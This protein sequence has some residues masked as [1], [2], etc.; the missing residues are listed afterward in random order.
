MLGRNRCLL[1]SGLS[2]VHLINLKS[3]RGAGGAL[4]ILDWLCFCSTPGGG[5]SQRDRNT[6]ATAYT[7]MYT[8]THTNTHACLHTQTHTHAFQS[9]T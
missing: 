4:S 5:A 9:F 6:L 2:E 1:K 7:H 8:H 3:L